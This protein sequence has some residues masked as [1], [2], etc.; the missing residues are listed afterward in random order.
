ML[1][2]C[3]APAAPSPRSLA[4]EGRGSRAPAR[5][6]DGGTFAAANYAPRWRPRESAQQRHRPHRQNAKM[7]STPASTPVKGDLC[8]SGDAEGTSL[9]LRKILCLGEVW[10]P[11]VRE[12]LRG[13]G[14]GGKGPRRGPLTPPLPVAGSP[15]PG[16]H[17]QRRGAHAEETILPSSLRSLL[18]LCALGVE[19]V[20]LSPS[21]VGRVLPGRAGYETRPASRASPVF[22]CHLPPHR[23]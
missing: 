20:F 18:P 9:P 1:R 17:L 7:Y 15:W 16:E 13:L 2:S 6:A 21:V 22:S 3:A 12:V 5:S 4:E 14:T 8:E 23:A 19:A 10:W 11:E